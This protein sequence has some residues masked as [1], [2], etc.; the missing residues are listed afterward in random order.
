MARF[1]GHRLREGGRR[2]GPRLQQAQAER[3]ADQPLLGSVVQVALDP[4]SLG[5]TG[6]YEPEPRG[7]Q[8]FDLRQR[9][10][11]ELLVLEAQMDRRHQLVGGVATRE[12]ARAVDQHRQGTPC[13]FERSQRRP[14]G[15]A[16]ETGRAAASTKRAPS[17]TE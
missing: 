16:V 17:S 8:V 12:C 7:P 5:V 6:L 2:A 3:Q 14:A 1:L 13:M 4:T 11:P 9:L 15:T 10:G